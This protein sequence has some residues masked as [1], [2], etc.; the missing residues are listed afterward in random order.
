MPYYQLISVNN[1]TVLCERLSIKLGPTDMGSG[2]ALLGETLRRAKTL[3]RCHG[4]RDDVTNHKSPAH[5][6]DSFLAH[7]LDC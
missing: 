7:T 2:L 1:Q 6:R 5:G 4:T 3:K